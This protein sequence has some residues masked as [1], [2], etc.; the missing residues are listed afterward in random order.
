MADDIAININFSLGDGQTV[1]DIVTRL[2]RHN[3]D[4][5]PDVHTPCDYCDALY[6]IE[7][8]R[9]AIDTVLLNIT[10]EGSH[11]EYHAE[12]RRRHEQEWPTLW[13][14]IAAMREARR[15]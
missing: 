4:W 15:G 2:R 14:A 7:R 12:L 9:D 8:L 5:L 6:E 10:D 3:H 13:R 11:P 1:N